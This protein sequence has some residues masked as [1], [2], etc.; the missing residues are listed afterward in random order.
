[1]DFLGKNIRDFL[2]SLVAFLIILVLLL[3]SYRFFVSKK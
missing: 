2:T 1:M 3:G